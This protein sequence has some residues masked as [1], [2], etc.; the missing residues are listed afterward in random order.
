MNDE[1]DYPDAWSGS[2]WETSTQAMTG[3]AEGRRSAERR[4][5][6]PAS[7]RPM[8]SSPAAKPAVSPVEA[9][10]QVV[11]WV[12]DLRWQRTSWCARG[13]SADARTYA[14]SST[15]ANTPHLDGLMTGSVYKEHEVQEVQSVQRVQ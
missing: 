14:A 2:F 15:R 12:E 8:P 7:R 5:A 13:R 4:K 11:Q 9:T 6:R 1:T 10:T 3:G